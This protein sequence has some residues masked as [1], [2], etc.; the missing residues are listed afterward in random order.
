MDLFS[1]FDA[2]V[3][4]EQHASAELSRLSSL[5]DRHN[6]LYHEKDAPEISDAE[7]DS[8]CL[9]YDSL[10][11]T[12]PS[13]PARKVGAPS[14]SI[15]KKVRHAQPMLSLE[16]SFD[17]ADVENFLSN[18]RSMLNLQ[19]NEALTI[20]AEPKIDGLS[21]SLR[22]ENGKLVTAATRGNGEHGEDVTPN[23]LTIC[24]IPQMLTGTY[25]A[26]IEVRGEVY[27]SRSEFKA[28]NAQ[29][30]ITGQ[31]LISNPRNGASGALRQKDPRETAKRGLKFFAYALGELSEPICSN[32]TELNTALQNLG[33]QTNPF[34]K[35][36]DSIEDLIAHYDLIAQKRSELDYDIDG[37]VYKIDSLDYQKNLGNVSRT[38]RWATA[39]KFPAEQA[40]TRLIGIDIQVGRTGA[41]TP[42]ARLEPINVG[43]VIVSNATLHNEDEIARKDLRIGDLVIVQRAGDVIPQ[44]VGVS[45]SDEDRTQRDQFKFPNTCAACNSPSIRLKDEAVHRCTAGL[46]C[47]AQRT[48]RLIHMVSRDALN[49]EGFGSEAVHEFVEAGLIKEPA[50]IFTLHRNRGK[51]TLR[52]GW[53]AASV[54]KLLFAIEARRTVPLNRYLYC[55]G[56]HQVGR[57]ASKE[58]AKRYQ[59]F[60]D[61]MAFIDDGIAK[62]AAMELTG[63]TAL[64][65]RKMAEALADWVGIRG[66]GPEIIT[67]LLNFF[68]NGSTRSIALNLASE[69]TIENVDTEVRS[70]PITGKTIV[71]TGS[72]QTMTREEAKATAEALGAKAAGSI[73]KKTD[74]LVYGPG[75]GSKLQKANELGVKTITEDQWQTLIQPCL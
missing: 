23:A 63:G 73:S 34:F 33:F 65:E 53:G 36:C 74:L 68:S 19:N 50:D 18:V 6:E 32:Q 69:M 11:A 45:P 67:A 13:S 22:Y 51:L 58:F 17:T 9:Q 38:P 5:I 59:S 15:F 31:K 28:I 39:H 25:P 24:D 72:L 41:Q 10:A 46:G 52:D 27:M 56:I 40:I 61:L 60:G 64:T 16:N 55:L 21:L 37:V 54:E 3:T 8:L 4:T 49:I 30:E 42:V 7:F 29:R 70:S 75:A 47:S 66:I 14:S 20:S 57:T 71:F 1:S 43:G 12:L 44:V 48:E 62:R 35:A 2:P 26:T